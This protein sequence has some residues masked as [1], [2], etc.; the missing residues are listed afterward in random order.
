MRRYVVFAIACV[1]ALLLSRELTL[2]LP[3]VGMGP[4][5]LILVVA[6]FAIGERPRTAATAGV[7][8][9]VSCATCCS[10]T[11]TGLSAFAYAVTGV[12]RR[13][14]RYPARRRAGRR[15]VRRRD[16]RL[17]AALR[18]RRGV[19]RPPGGRVA[20]AADALH[21][22][23]V[24]CAD[25]APAHA[26]ALARRARRERRAPP[27]SRSRMRRANERPHEPEP[28]HQPDPARGRAAA[29][30][31]AARDARRTALVPPGARGRR[32]AGARRADVDP[33]RLRAGAARIRL[34]PRG[35]DARAEPH[36]AHRR[37]RRVARAGRTART[38]SS[39][40]SRARCE[41]EET[42]VRDIVNDPTASAR[43]RLVR[44]RSTSTR[45]SSST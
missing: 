1:L 44:S 2:S 8:R 4:D 9:R 11:P 23:R 41:M 22:H 32:G 29:R 42:D 20:S 13:A 15:D 36:G 12:R 45:T 40:T 39:A 21:H 34:R 43:T 24:Q 38:R 18:A 16:V 31:V 30:P 5:L 19:P 37:A 14:D 17:A 25:L 7:R 3:M 26:A 35:P 27:W 28:E 10:M 6:A 33:V